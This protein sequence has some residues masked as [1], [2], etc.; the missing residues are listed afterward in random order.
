MSNVSN[1][2][3]EPGSTILGARPGSAAFAARLTKFG[4][5][6]TTKR[7]EAILLTDNVAGAYHLTVNG[8]VQTLLAPGKAIYTNPHGD[9]IPYYLG[10]S[11][12]LLA[13]CHASGIM[14][15]SLTASCATIWLEKNLP[16]NAT[17]LDFFRIGTAFRGDKHA[18]LATW[19]TEPAALYKIVVAPVSLIIG[20]GTTIVKGAIDDNV[21]ANIRDSHGDVGIVWLGTVQNFDRAAQTA[22]EDDATA[23]GDDF[24]S[25]RPKQHWA[26]TT[27]IPTDGFQLFDEDSDGMTSLQARVAAFQPAPPS[28]REGVPPTTDGSV[29]GGSLATAN[30]TGLSQQD[31]TPP[32]KTKGRSRETAMVQ[33]YYACRIGDPKDPY[34]QAE[35]APPILTAKGTD[36]F[37]ETD[38][39]TA[40][41]LLSEGMDEAYPDMSAKE[42]Y[43]MKAAKYTPPGDYVTACIAQGS[44]CHSPITDIQDATLL[45]GLNLACFLAFTRGDATTADLNST[46]N[47]QELVGE[48]ATNTVK[49]SAKV[50]I[51]TYLDGRNG[52]NALAGNFLL[53]AYT[54]FNIDTANGGRLPEVVRCVSS[55]VDVINEPR[56][57]KW[58]DN[59]KSIEDNCAW[60]AYTQLEQLH[61]LAARCARSSANQRAW[62]NG[63]HSDT[64]VLDAQADMH[65]IVENTDRVI[66]HAST[67]GPQLT[68]TD[69]IKSTPDYK[70]AR[71]KDERAAKAVI[72]AQIAAAVAAATKQFTLKR[73]APGQ[74]DKAPKDKS[75]G[76]GGTERDTKGDII[77]EGTG[78]MPLPTITNATE[79]PCAPHIRHGKYCTRSNCGHKPLDRC[80]KT[81]QDEWFAF[82]KDTDGMSFHESV[83]F[84]KKR[85][86]LTKAE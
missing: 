47:A 83:S 69:I 10:T 9:E 86:K 55:I 20:Y 62:S 74:T 68:T 75:K 19:T 27:M 76:K 66:R 7:D 52:V 12:N 29:A 39:K 25:K 59:D 38:V 79:Q 35:A 5:A 64:T 23:L 37:E 61:L 33:L 2:S 32:T 67:G 13:Q 65:R 78:P 6:T 48:L 41:E 21:H 28:Q 81:T 18:S 45:R 80:T 54:M 31:V 44:Y 73:N 82:V 43:L 11:S 70:I 72:D 26:T 3:P 40:N 42:H 30:P 85:L 50:C 77:F 58:M 49:R 71:A 51:A 63:K 57:R 53:P 1:W 24:P 46:R 56:V 34:S 4:K 16:T 60:F 15:R 17:G 36:I 14:A 22:M 84:I 8:R